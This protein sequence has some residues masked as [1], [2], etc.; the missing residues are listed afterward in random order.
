MRT[1]IIVNKY[2]ALIS[3]ITL[4][5]FILIRDI[6]YREHLT[7]TSLTIEGGRHSERTNELSNLYVLLNDAVIKY[8]ND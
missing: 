7:I 4:T 3:E 5:E 1:A 2:E 8:N 6:L